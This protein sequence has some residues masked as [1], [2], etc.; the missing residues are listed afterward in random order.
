MTIQLTRSDTT[1]LYQLAPFPSISLSVEFGLRASTLFFGPEES[2]PTQITAL[3]QALKQRPS[4]LESRFRLAQ[5]L[6]VS[7]SPEAPRQLEAVIKEAS[8]RLKTSPNNIELLLKLGA[9]HQRQERNSVAEPFFRRV[10]QLAPQDWRGWLG[11]G[12]L[13]SVQVFTG[14]GLSKLQ[15][16]KVQAIL[17]NPSPAAVQELAKVFLKE[18]LAPKQLESIRALSA[19]AA[20][21]FDKAVALAPELPTVYITRAVNRSMSSSEFWEYLAKPTPNYTIFSSSF[22]ADLGKARLLSGQSPYQLT[23]LAMLEFIGLYTQS[24]PKGAS[25]EELDFSRLTA[26]V[27][28]PVVQATAQLTSLLQSTNRPQR[29]SALEGL[30]LFSFF[31]ADTDAAQRYLRQAQELGALTKTS[32][33]LLL[34]QYIQAKNLPEAEA[35][36]QK[37]I[38]ATPTLE[39]YRLMIRL[40]DQR[41]KITERNALLE[42]TQKSHP[43]DTFCLLGQSARWLQEGKVQKAAPYLRSLHSKFKNTFMSDEE[44]QERD[45]LQAVALAL[46]AKPTE[47]RALLK[48]VLEQDSQNEAARAILAVLTR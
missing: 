2:W 45:V 38:K 48:G 21:C 26:E 14:N 3:K 27:K 6:S 24:Q 34:A 22:F 32:T 30:A 16:E 7:E 8:R 42:A 19:E 12:S 9:C 13:L 39:N 20:V 28:E 31:Q 37:T 36:L 46:G 11:L 10:I 15:V 18:R 23:I 33:H 17:S 25:L 43:D 40:L 44:K 1:R 29:K 47:A 5:L 41:K 4:D 35:F